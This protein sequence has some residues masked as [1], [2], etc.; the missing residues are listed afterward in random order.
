MSVFHGWLCKAI[1]VVAVLGLAGT[2]LCCDVLSF[3][4]FDALGKPTVSRQVL[5][6]TE[7]EAAMEPADI[8][9]ANDG[10][11]FI[12]GSIS[13]TRQGWAAKTDAEGKVLWNYYRELQEEDK[14]AFTHQLVIDP[15]FRAAVP[16]ADG[17][18]YLCG[19][20]PHPPRS[21]AP[22]AFLTHLDAQGHLLSEKFFV[23]DKKTKQGITGGFTGCIRWG[24]DIAIVGNTSGPISPPT[25]KR[26]HMREFFLGCFCSML[27]EM[28]NGRDIS[29]RKVFYE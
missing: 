26:R 5:I 13:G 18:V 7:R 29:Q 16:M 21:S 15:E 12:A 20:M 3:T 17:S 4:A 14:S 9:R 1:V 6:K 19:N 22:G 8:V 2:Y 23:P 27:E 24:N 11:F 28:S 10:G 25:K